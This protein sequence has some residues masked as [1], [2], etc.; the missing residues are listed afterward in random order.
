MGSTVRRKEYP[1]REVTDFA[2]RQI[3]PF[4][5]PEGQQLYLVNDRDAVFEAEIWSRHDI[6]DAFALRGFFSVILSIPSIDQLDRIFKDILNFD[7]LERSLWIDQQSKTVVYSTLQGGGAGS[8][9][10][11]LE[12]PHEGRS[13]LGAGGTH[14]VAFKVKD[15]ETQKDWHKHLSQAGFRIS[16]LIDRFWFK[17]IYFQVSNNILFEIATDGPGFDIDEETENL[18]EKLI[19]P[20]ISGKSPTGNRSWFNPHWSIKQMTVNIHLNQPVKHHGVELD[21]AD[22]IVI[23][24]HGRGSNA[25]SMMP[26]AEALHDRRGPIHNSSSGP[27]PLVSSHCLRTPSSQRT[28]SVFCSNNH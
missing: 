7:E 2:E 25:K 21:E 22:L 10:W 11:L 24:L 20:S 3:L 9:V 27:K 28:R 5:D 6:P 12:Q 19:L 4:E 17:S 16:G 13:R 26:I 23:L 8:E 1:E 18:G 14:H 15:F